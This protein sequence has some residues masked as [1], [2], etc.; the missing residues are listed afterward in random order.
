MSG[1]VKDQKQIRKAT[2]DFAVAFL[3]F[4]LLSYVLV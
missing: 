1:T 2:A 3:C 4:I